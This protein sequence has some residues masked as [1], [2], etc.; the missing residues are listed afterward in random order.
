LRLVV[1]VRPIAA[2]LAAA[3]A[4]LAAAV[5]AAR[6]ALAAAAGLAA[7]PRG[8]VVVAAAAVAAAEACRRGLVGL[9]S[10]VPGSGVAFGNRPPRG[11]SAAPVVRAGRGLVVVV[12][13]RTTAAVAGRRLLPTHRRTP[14]AAV[15]AA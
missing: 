4:A 6:N 2:F 13:P 7:V 12:R 15:F 3:T 10:V 11:A 5:A 14:A 9:G 8:V 1:V